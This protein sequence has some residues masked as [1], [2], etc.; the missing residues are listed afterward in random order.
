MLFSHGSQWVEWRKE[1]LLLSAEQWSQS[2]F[3]TYATLFF[4]LIFPNPTCSELATFEL[5]SQDQKLGNFGSNFHCIAL[6]KWELWRGLW[7]STWG[8][9][10]WKTGHE[11]VVCTHSLGSQPYPGLHLKSMASRTFSLSALES[12]LCRSR[13]GPWR[14]SKGRST[15]IGEKALGKPDY[16]LLVLKEMSKYI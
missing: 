5:Q 6:R 15:S 7:R 4:L 1:H 16:D 13:G 14:C 9:G 10:E 11:L 2:K 12:C 8:A 3:Q